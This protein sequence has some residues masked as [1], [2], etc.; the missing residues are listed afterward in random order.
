MDYCN[1]DF[2]RLRNDLIDYFMSA[3]FVATP[4]AMMDA[5]DV[6]NASDVELINIA[7]ENH[8]DLS[9]YMCNYSR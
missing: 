1:I 3:A 5:I 9:K 7:L 6:E 2:E 8:F 4:A